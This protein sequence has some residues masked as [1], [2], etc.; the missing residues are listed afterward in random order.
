MGTT[1]RVARA[2][3]LAA[4]TASA[5]GSALGGAPR[6]A[7][8]QTD[9]SFQGKTVTIIIGY[10]PGGL[11]DLTARLLSRHMG[12]HLPGAPAMVPQ[13]MVGASSYKAI[14]H[15]YGVAPKDGT[16]I[17]MISRG[18]ANDNN[19]SPEMGNYD[20]TQLRAVGSTSSEV[21]VAV[22]WHTSPIK[23]FADTLTR[24]VTVGSTGLNSP[25]ARFAVMVKN[26][27]GSKVKIVTGYPGGNE[28]TLAMERGEVDG[29]FGWSWGSVK[30]RSKQWLDEKKINIIFQMGLAK[31]PDLPDTPFIMDFARDDR[32]RRALELLTAQQAFAW[33]VVAPRGIESDK[34]EAL[35]RAFDAT[36]TDAQFLADAKKL[37]IEIEPMRGADIDVIVKRVNSFDPAVVQHALSLIKEK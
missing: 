31:A 5:F 19:L 2:Y 10:A 26:L 25:E 24:E 20:P 23:T 27:T 7:A 8:A 21:S 33:P 11:Y 22:T 32:D 16:T 6:D 14:M 9:P 12:R 30:S 36:M 17:G 13:N 15:L 1:G 34:L 37:G 28:V 35:R 29:R 18:F 4:I 3:A